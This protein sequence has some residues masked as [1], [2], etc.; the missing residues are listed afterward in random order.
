M[1][2]PPSDPLSPALPEQSVKRLLPLAEPEFAGQIE[3]TEAPV[4]VEYFPS[5]QLKQAEASD[6]W[7]IEICGNAPV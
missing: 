4:A 2:G 5:G 1:Q 6:R 3:H 7:P